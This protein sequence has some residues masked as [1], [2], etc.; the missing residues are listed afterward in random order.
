VEDAR[1][2]LYLASAEGVARIDHASIARGPANL[3]IASRYTVSDGLAGTEV[4]GAYADHVGRLWFATTQGLSYYVP[5][6]PAD[7]PAPR[8]RIGGVRI[9]GVEQ[10]VSPA[11]DDRIADFELSPGRSQLEIGFF[12]IDL[13]AG[14]A[15][16]FEYRLVG[17]GDDWSAP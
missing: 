11:G 5:E 13:T 4:G 7:A 16:S 15:L 6:A 3:R 1:G 9:A 14:S 12:G 2:S 10:R 8:V 17:A